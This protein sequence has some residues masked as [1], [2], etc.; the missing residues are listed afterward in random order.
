MG[1][2][3]S[4]EKL[5]EVTGESAARLREWHRIGLLP[6]GEGG[7]PAQHAERIRLI[8]FADQRGIDPEDLAKVSASQGDLLSSF[9]DSLGVGVRTRTY[10]WTQARELVGIPPDALE[11]GRVAAGLAGQAYLYEEDVQ[12]LRWAADAVDSGLPEDG[13]LQVLRV[14]ADSS[15]RAAETI[16]K[17][18]HLYVHEQF[19][20]SG[21][22]GKDLFAATQ[23]VTTPLQGIVEPA[24]MYFHRKAWER[25]IR[26]DL[27]LHLVEDATPHAEVPGQL[28]RT[29][30][31]VDLSSFTPLTEVMGDAIAAQVV[32]RFGHVVR[33]AAAS[34]DGQVVKQIGDAFMLVFPTPRSA[35][36]CGL[37]IEAQVS[38]EPRFPAVRIGIHAG[39]LLYREGDYLGANVNLAA[40]VAAAAARHQL[41]V[42]EAVR[43]EADGLEGVEFSSIGL[44]GLKGVSGE[45]ELFEVRQVSDRPLRPVDPVCGMELDADTIE[46]TLTWHGEQLS[47]CSANCLERFA[48]DPGRYEPG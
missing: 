38:A 20:A 26:D 40:R 24:V 6:E 35:V 27:V 29:L 3:V 28:F 25:A 33:D 31:F 7:F 41:L 14:L 12:A 23:S 21:L 18:V 17:V 44:R 32:D 42:T 39:L 8:Q 46:A 13:V 36:T 43:E 22:S 2:E 48:R 9:V 4:L 37:A 11:R 15:N 19:R 34:C 30:L 47:F 16:N 10:S 45:V 5:A 1:E